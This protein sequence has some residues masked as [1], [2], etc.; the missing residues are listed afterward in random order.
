MRSVG[1]AILAIFSWIHKTFLH[2]LLFVFFQLW[3]YDTMHNS[4]QHVRECVSWWSGISYVLAA[5]SVTI[6]AFSKVMFSALC[7][8]PSVEDQGP[9]VV[10]LVWPLPCNQSGMVRPAGLLQSGVVYHR[11]FSIRPVWRSNTSQSLLGSTWLQIKASHYPTGCCVVISVCEAAMCLQAAGHILGGCCAQLHWESVWAS[12]NVLMEITAEHMIA[13]TSAVM[14]RPTSKN[15]AHAHRPTH[16]HTHT[17]TQAH[18]CTCAHTFTCF[19]S[20]SWSQH[21]HK[22]NALLT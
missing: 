7:P 1:G 9:F 16:T 18:M 11:L 8:T 21:S 3:H 5:V 13:P 2:V 14:L 17:Y 19:H 22:T 20:P 6:A 10:H 4:V 15:F 12:R